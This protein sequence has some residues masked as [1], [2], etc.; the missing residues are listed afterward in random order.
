MAHG[1]FKPCHGCG[2]EGY[3]AV[4]EVCKKCRGLLRAARAIQ[5]DEEAKAEAGK[6]YRL[7]HEWPA[8]YI[9]SN[10][11]ET[12]L[13]LRQAFERLAHSVLRPV[14][15]KKDP[16]DPDVLE[17]PP[18]GDLVNY[19]STFDP[20]ATVWTG[21]ARTARALVNLDSQVRKALSLS[22]EI[23]EQEGSNLLMQIAQGKIS[24][25]ELTEASI[26]AGR[27]RK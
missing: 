21:T 26:E 4:D 15:S 19:F 5:Q 10:D 16:Y 3:R 7:T 6:L 23:G 9:P 20:K 25:N 22:R 24:V 11:P 14:R 1:T 13:Q 8:F 18:K 12:G 27:H 2:E 17:L